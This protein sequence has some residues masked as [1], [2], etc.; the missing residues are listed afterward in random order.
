MKIE[1]CVLD[2]ASSPGLCEGWPCLEDLWTSMS[3]LL[4][5][6]TDVWRLFGIL[7]P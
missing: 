5:E 2:P 6:L 1:P 3:A 4:L 7:F